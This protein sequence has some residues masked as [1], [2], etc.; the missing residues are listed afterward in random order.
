MKYP[1]GAARRLLP[2]YLLV[3]GL[4]CAMPQVASAIV[5][6]LEADPN[7][8]ATGSYTISWNN[9]GDGTFR[10]QERIGGTGTW[11]SIHFTATGSSFTVTNK[12]PGEYHYRIVWSVRFCEPGL[13]FGRTSR[14]F[15]DE[16]TRNSETLAVTVTNPVPGKPQNVSTDP[17]PDPIGGPLLVKTNDDY[18]IYWSAVAGATSYELQ[19]RLDNSPVVGDPAIGIW[20]T[21]YSGP[22][23][24]VSF[25]PKKIESAWSYR[26]R[27]CDANSVCGE[28]SDTRQVVVFLWVPPPE[29]PPPPPT[30]QDEIQATWNQFRTALDNGDVTAAMQFISPTAH[31]RY[32]P[33]LLALGDNVRNLTAGWSEIKEIR[34]DSEFA[35]YT[36]FVTRDGQ[37]RLH[38]VTLQLQEGVWRLLEF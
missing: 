16:F 32:E 10:L 23:T 4:M 31:S 3:V 15:C 26:V 27:A 22:L 25:Y 28:W 2:R 24:T 38:I 1:F 30:E 17:A 33:A 35:E 6:G 19:E 9:Y 12:L 36:V 14:R 29:P 8:S 5:L 11:Y 37:T 34:V 13:E 18:S 20:N 7:P 21:T